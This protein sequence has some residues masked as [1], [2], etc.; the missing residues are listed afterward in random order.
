MTVT[1]GAPLA[2]RFAGIER[3]V[4]DDAV[5]RAG[6]ARVGELRLRRF[7]AAAGGVALRGRGLELLIVGE[8][9]QVVE[10][11]ARRLVLAARL[12]ERDLR[13]VD[14]LLRDRAFSIEALAVVEDRLLRVDGVLGRARVELG[15][16]QLLRNR[17]L[18]RRL[19]RRLG[20]I[21][22][23]AALGGRSRRDRGFPAR[24][25]ADPRGRGRRAARTASSP[26]PRSSGRS[27]PADADRAGRRRE[28][29]AGSS[30]SSTGATSTVTTGAASSSRLAAAARDS[31][32]AA[33][34]SMPRA[35]PVCLAV[36]IRSFPSGS[37][38]P[39][40]PRDTAPRHRR[41]RCAPGRACSA[42]PTTSS[43][44]DS[45]A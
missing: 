27:R 9:L 11:L 43:A 23:R 35:T 3:Q 14:V 31:S 44:V 13:V 38:A 6:D 21:Q 12:A 40:A 32:A 33:T 42:R 29:C 36:I 22:R 28:S 45:P 15:L 7:V 4:G 10:T 19:E 18:R 5:D 24:R 20:Q 26:A 39:R 30:T 41:P 34:A 37:A 25:A 8:A 2:G 1:T 17:R 16:L